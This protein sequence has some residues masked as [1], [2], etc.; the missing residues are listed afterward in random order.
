MRSQSWLSG[1]RCRSRCH[2]L[3]W[4]Q[5]RAL[6]PAGRSGLRRMDRS[7]A[8][9]RQRPVEERRRAQGRH[10]AG[11]QSSARCSVRWRCRVTL[12]GRAAGLTAWAR[13]GKHAQAARGRARRRQTLTLALRCAR[14]RS[15]TNA[16]SAAASSAAPTDTSTTA[17]RTPC[18]AAPRTPLA[19]P[20]GCGK[21]YGWSWRRRLTSGPAS[22][23][24]GICARQQGRRQQRA[25]Q[26]RTSSM[27][28]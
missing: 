15:T 20:D 23:Q 22:C 13:D 28:T 4:H 27:A 16:P 7:A 9:A 26:H 18:D 14:S 11:G 10:A 17:A 2:S 8:A 21:A 24:M 12:G 25:K 3:C 5:T 6:R 1:C 19:W